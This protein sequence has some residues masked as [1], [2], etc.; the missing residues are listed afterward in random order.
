MSGRIAMRRAS[1]VRCVV[2]VVTEDERG[3]FFARAEVGLDVLNCGPF[4]T[5]LGCL[6]KMGQHINH[7]LSAV[8]QQQTA[9][10]DS[11]EA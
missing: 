8:Q 4:A 9:Q 7:H 5:R 3:D 6:D 11:N 1:R 2:I 10:T